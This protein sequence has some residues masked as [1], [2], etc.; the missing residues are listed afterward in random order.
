MGKKSS[1]DGRF[2]G[3]ADAVV[4]VG[5]ADAAGLVITTAGDDGTAGLC[6]VLVAGAEVVAC[7]G[8][9]GP[10]AEPRRDVAGVDSPDDGD[11][12]DDVDVDAIN[13]VDT[14]VDDEHEEDEAAEEAVVG[15]DDGVVV[16]EV[17]VDENGVAAD[18]KGSHAAA[19]PN[20]SND[21]AGNDDNSVSSGGEPTTAPAAAAAV[22]VAAAGTA[23]LTIPPLLVSLLLVVVPVL[24]DA[25]LPVT[26]D[27]ISLGMDTDDDRG[28]P[29]SDSSDVSCGSVVSSVDSDAGTLPI[30][31]P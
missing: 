17:A 11:G 28:A 6:G 26:D 1:A 21:G 3:L 4:V 29:P 24:M 5:V 30:T 20:G 12:N 23:T 9:E 13:N 25:S 7:A 19:S 31:L 27:D 22:A 18:E 14:N 15:A 8:V 16:V 2:S 10:L